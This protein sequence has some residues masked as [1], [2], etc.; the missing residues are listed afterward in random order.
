MISV[1]QL[2]LTTVSR[3]LHGTATLM[4]D[5]TALFA[6]ENREALVRPDDPRFPMMTSYAG[7]L[8]FGDPDQA[9]PV[10]QIFYPPYLFIKNTNGARAARPTILNSPSEISYRGSF[11][12]Q[13]DRAFGDIGS[14]VLLR[15]DHNTHSLTA[16]DRYVKLAFG[17]KGDPRTGGLRVV[18]PML[19]A[20]AVPGVYMLFVVDKQGV[21]SEGRQVRLKPETRGTTTPFR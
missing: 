4:P 14:V 16:G 10:G 15:S 18:S 11:D 12:V 19:P 5:G 8:P 13:V 20:Q 6:G 17:V 2:A 21:P 9:V 7:E 3:G 1:K